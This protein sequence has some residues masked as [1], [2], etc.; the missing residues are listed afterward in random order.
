MTKEHLCAYCR[1]L[2]FSEQD[3][4]PQT[5]VLSCAAFPTGI[6]A[7]IASGAVDHD[8]PYEGDKGIQFEPENEAAAST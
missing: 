3:P 8:R 5:R 4:A 7:P 1:H 2:N 6:P